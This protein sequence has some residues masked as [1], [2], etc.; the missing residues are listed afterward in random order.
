MN[1]IKTK[2]GYALTTPE[3]VVVAAFPHYNQAAQYR[4]YL[5]GE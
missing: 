1:I 4:A 3:G 2:E 5:L